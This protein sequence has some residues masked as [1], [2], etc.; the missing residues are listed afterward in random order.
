MSKPKRLLGR[1]VTEISDPSPRP[2]VGKVVGQV[3]ERVVEVHWGP[4]RHDRNPGPGTYE[5]VERLRPR[6]RFRG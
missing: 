4:R 6:G 3:D 2:V 1:E 5:P